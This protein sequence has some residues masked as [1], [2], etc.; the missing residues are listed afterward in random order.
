MSTTGK[1]V[2][3]VMAAVLLA[4]LIAFWGSVFGGICLLALGAMAVTWIRQWFA[5]QGDPLDYSDSPEDEK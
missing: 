2:M 5:R 3:T 1:I 4:C